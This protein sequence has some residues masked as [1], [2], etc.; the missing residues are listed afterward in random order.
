MA[1]VLAGMAAGRANGQIL[2]GSIVGDVIDAAGAVVPAAGVTIVHQETNQSRSTT[3]NP[4]GQ[5]TFPTI[6]TGTYTVTVTAPGFRT[7]TQREVA[8][9]VNSQTRVNIQLEVG[10]VTESVTVSATGVTLQTDRAEVR[11]E[12]HEEILRDAPIPLGGNYQQL[13]ITLPGFSPPEDAHSVPSNPSRALQFSVNGTSRSLNNTRI[14]GASSTN[15]WLPHMVAYVPSRE[16]IETVNVVTNSFDAEQGLAGGAA[17]NVQIKSGTNT[18]HGSA[19]APH[20]NQ[21]IKTYPWVSDKNQPQPKF[22]Y[23]QF[24]AT[25]GGPI[26]RDKL[27][28]FV[29]YEG[30]RE[31]QAASKFLTVPTPAMKT[32]DLTGSPTAIYDPLTGDDEGRNRTPF[33]GN[34]IPRSRIDSGVQ[35]ILDSGLWPNPN[36]RGTGALGLTR[37]YLAVGPTSFFRDTVDTKVNWNVSPRLSTFVRFSVLDFRMSN[38]HVFG[39]LGG[40]YLHPTNNNPGNGFGNT[41]SGTLSATYVVNPSL[42][43]DAYF[44]YTLM[45]TNVEQPRL[46]EKLGLDYLGIPG[47]NGRRRWEGGWPRFR[48]DGFAELGLPNDYMPYYRHD[49]QWQYVANANWTRG[50][51]NIRFGLDFY[52]QH[53]NHNQ[54][55]VSGSGNNPAAGGFHF[56]QGITQT[57]GGPGGNDYNAIGSFLLGLARDAGK[58]YQY[59]D[60]GYTTRARLFSLY[61]RDQWQV[62]RRLTFTFGTRW[63]YFPFPR[64]ADRGLERYDFDANKILACGHGVVPLDCG[65]RVGAAHFAPRA[66]VAW[67]VTNTFVVRAGYG[68][69]TDPF[70]WS[71]PLRT[72]Y[73]VLANQ[74]ID[75]AN[76]Y[77]WATTLRQGLRDI[78]EPPLGNG[79]LDLPL[80]ATVLTADPNN[81]VRGYIQSWNFTLEKELPGGWMGSAGYVATRSVNQMALLDQNWSPIGGGTPGRQMVVRFG[82][83]A[84]TDMLGSVGTPKYDS[85]QLRVIRRHRSGQVRV[86]YTWGHGRGY[87]GESSGGDT[88]VDIPS[89]YWRN[90]GNLSQDIRHN[91]QVTSTI[92]L[93]FGKRK[94]WANSGAGAAILGGWQLNAVFSAYTGRPFT[95]SGSGTSL[96][97]PSAGQFADCLAPPIKL[98][99][100][101]GWYDRSTFASV[102]TTEV[103]FG[104]CGINSI[105]A[106]GLIN[107][108]TSVFRRFH[109]TER[110][111]LQFRAEV[112]N[113]SNTPHFG[114]PNGSQNNSNFMVITD[115]RNIGR[116]GRSERLHRFALRLA[117]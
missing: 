8:V 94:R 97:T 64:R 2:Y 52:L 9:T 86:G 16:A 59:G 107:G 102:P 51:H 12:I 61:A 3:T 117:W 29:S 10:A 5:Y 37:N 60:D 66:G 6:A 50:K 111:T 99:R 101:E 53:L 57:R 24:G 70:N 98:G 43:L 85:M 93:P 116:E 89:E 115:V 71:R 13:F 46:D 78:P 90:Y 41:F 68:I 42:L 83:T 18:V 33:A 75:S 48:I 31:A 23:N 113:V 74:V 95:V 100:P 55:E 63:E 91:L 20:T 22:I 1:L 27:F 72:N 114:A 81:T 103:R 25:I 56:T 106:P 104:T 21:H 77:F 58:I 26:R 36:Q 87:T 28:Y 112:F 109:L 65:I 4:A 96:N 35:K 40:L 49:P 67:R 30:T 11:D 19:F 73:P 34:L 82:R 88:R 32:G 15:L 47:T 80:T 38:P 69:T 110:V 14:D 84:A 92:E 45:D 54:P 79:I 108:D 7:A 17:V 44:G 105:R 39:D 62:N 76:T